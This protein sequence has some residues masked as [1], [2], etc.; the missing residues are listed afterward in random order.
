LAHEVRCCQV[1][2]CIRLERKTK[3]AQRHMSCLTIAL[4]ETR[5][6]VPSKNPSYATSRYA[7]SKLCLRFR[8]P[9]SVSGV[10]DNTFLTG[11][12][13]WGCTMVKPKASPKRLTMT[14]AND[15]LHCIAQCRKP[16][17]LMMRM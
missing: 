7:S 17:E 14:M 16:C 15:V 9:V 12:R 6:L 3:S 13:V 4:N 2:R 8:F 5:T 1:P 11:R 10:A